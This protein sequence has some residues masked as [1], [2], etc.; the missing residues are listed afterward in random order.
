MSWKEAV[1][2]VLRV[3]VD[4]GTKYPDP[5]LELLRVGVEHDDID[6][7]DVTVTLVLDGAIVTGTVVSLDVWERLFLRQLDDHDSNL[8]RATKTA[9]GHLDDTADEGR[10]RREPARPFLHLRDVTYRSGRSTHILPTW[11]GPI[12][13][14][15]GWTLG[16]PDQD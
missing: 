9:L 2:S 16:G 15:S 14:I 7:N 13:A 5:Y 6:A 8:R 4:Q 1:Q 3:L 12:D 10:R 11:R